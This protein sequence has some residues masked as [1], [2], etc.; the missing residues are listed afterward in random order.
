MTQI[1]NIIKYFIPPIIILLFNKLKTSSLLSKSIWSGDFDSWEQASS[2]CT[3]Y[4][5]GNIV[6]KVKSA[7]LK[8][9]NG[10]VPYERDSVLF[11]K[12]HYSFPIAAFLLWTATGNKL[13]VVDFGGSLGSSYFQNRFFLQKFE[14]IT[15]HIIEQQNYVNIG[16]KLFQDN[17]LQFH[18]SFEELLIE[19][20][21]DFDV[22]LLSS[23][24]QYI[25]KPYELLEKIAKLNIKNIIFDI[26]TIN[27]EL[28]DRITIQNVEPSIYEAS[29]P[30]WF[31]NEKKLI[32][33]FV[34]NN[35]K[36]ITDWQAPYQIDIGKHKGYFFT[37]NNI[38]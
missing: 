8:V 29:Y 16:K 13:T 35:Y 37:K 14:K 20:E 33:F 2:L 22:L 21:S 12:V 9:K 31:F 36:L 6:E 28:K 32:Y 3:G 5:A 1:K 10:E 11:D 7:T 19:K 38:L 4:D 34:Q 27:S 26:T 18:N 25:E 15:W 30:T 24:L 23:V 17:N